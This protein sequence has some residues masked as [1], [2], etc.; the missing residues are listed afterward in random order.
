MLSVKKN[1]RSKRYF[2][3]MLEGTYLWLLQKRHGEFRRFF[4]RE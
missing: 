3:D 1:V 4:F 2:I